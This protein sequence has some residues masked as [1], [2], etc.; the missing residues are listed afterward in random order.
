MALAAASGGITS[1]IVSGLVQVMF[2]IVYLVCNQYIKIAIHNQHAQPVPITITKRLSY[3][4][5]SGLR[6]RI[7]GS[8]T[9]V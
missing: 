7:T 6:F 8:V 2:S 4:T 1:T 3:V 5:A 9:Y